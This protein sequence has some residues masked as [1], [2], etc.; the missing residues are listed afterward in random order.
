LLIAGTSIAQSG[1]S[2]T[3]TQSV[4]ANGGGRSSDAQFS[5][6][7]T[8]GQHAAGAVS[9]AVPYRT[10][11]GFW[12]P[13]PLA[14]TAANVSIS[15]RVTTPEGYG[16]SNAI[17]LVTLQDG[18]TRIARSNPFGNYAI[19]GIEAGQTVIVMVSSKRFQ[20]PTQVVNLT[21]NVLV[22]F[23]ATAPGR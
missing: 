13:D 23:T 6:T 10:Y 4:I 15:G 14:P 8:A 22:N 7:G 9:N 1:G 12:T 3:I 5:I 2:Y 18:A 20:F 16:L 19:D 11:A 21:D 17:V